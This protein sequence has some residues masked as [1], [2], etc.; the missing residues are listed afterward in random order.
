MGGKRPDQYQIDPA[1]AGATDYKDRRNN[2]AIKEEE[3]QRL[4][5]QRAAEQREGTIPE[6]RENPAQQRERERKRGS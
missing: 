1:E 5:E 2:P 6:H 3:K 4:A